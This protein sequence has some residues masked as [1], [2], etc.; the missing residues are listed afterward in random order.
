MPTPP[1]P[2]G[3]PSSAK[4]APSSGSSLPGE[5]N[6]GETPATPATPAEG[7]GGKDSTN[8]HHPTSSSLSDVLREAGS[9]RP[10]AGS[11]I[12]Q[13]LGNPPS[14]LGGPPIAGIPFPEPN[15]DDSPTVITGPRPAGSP[16]QT[17]PPVAPATSEL[18]SVAG[19]RLG[20]FELI[21]AVGSGGMAAVLK[22]R[23]LE[24]GRI[25]ALKI[26]PPEAAYDAESVNRFK[27]EARAAARLDHE[28]VA[29]VYFCGEDQ[30]L[31]FIA[32]EFVEGET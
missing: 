1:D 23:D 31:H 25:V 30:G 7:N 8:S 5:G 18:Q 6:T 9:A 11:D 19:R 16:V 27:Q 28:N 10:T 32:F 12:I 4:H 29:R 17:P 21:E 15:T 3:R 22:A 20:H 24:L 14:S 2:N 26:L 13:M